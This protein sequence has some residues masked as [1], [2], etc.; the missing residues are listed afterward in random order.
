[1]E[2][3]YLKVA[4]A[5]H[6]VLTALL[7]RKVKGEERL[8]HLIPNS[9]KK[10]RVSL[11]NPYNTTKET[12]ES[13]IT[14]LCSPPMPQLPEILGDAKPVVTS[15][16]NVTFSSKLLYYRKQTCAHSSL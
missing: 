10:M 7:A 3:L 13:H 8:Y 9:L 1:M 12:M 15:F 4:G 11:H 2:A 14:H 5:N 6:Q 16:R